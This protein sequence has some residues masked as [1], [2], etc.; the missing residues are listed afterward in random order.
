MLIIIRR[1]NYFHDFEVDVN[2]LD[3]YKVLPKFLPTNNHLLIVLAKKN[4]KKMFSV[5][6]DF[7]ANKLIQ[8]CIALYS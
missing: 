8:K 1:N 3:V 4:H 7:I 2:F 5:I 6:I